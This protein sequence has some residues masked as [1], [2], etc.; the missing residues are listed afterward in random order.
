MA[1]NPDALTNL[2]ISYFK[3]IIISIVLIYATYVIAKSLA[4]QVPGIIGG[5]IV[6]LALLYIVFVNNKVR[7]LIMGKMKRQTKGTGV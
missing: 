1:N 4:G 6:G 3:L 2:V 5:I 7:K